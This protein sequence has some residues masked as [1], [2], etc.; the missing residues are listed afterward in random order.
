MEVV[1][2]EAQLVMVGRED[3]LVKLEVLEQVQEL[4][5][6]T[7]ALVEVE[8]VEFYLVLVVLVLE[9]PVG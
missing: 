8:E 1:R 6:L 3:Y 9:A 5:L 2:V 7:T 4:I